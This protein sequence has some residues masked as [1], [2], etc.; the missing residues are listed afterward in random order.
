MV[1]RAPGICRRDPSG[2][3]WGAV[4]WIHSDLVTDEE[5]EVQREDWFAQEGRAEW[6]L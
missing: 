3:G 4:S 2:S 5:I 1:S 6:D